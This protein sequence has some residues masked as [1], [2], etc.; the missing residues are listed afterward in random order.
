MSGPKFKKKYNDTTVEKT[1][2]FFRKRMSDKKESLIC[3]SVEK[4]LKECNEE[5]R[6]GIILYLNRFSKWY[7]KYYEKLPGD[8]FKRVYLKTICILWRNKNNERWAVMGLDETK[9][10]HDLMTHVSNL[11]AALFSSERYRLYN[12]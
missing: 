10:G 11:F 6:N 8:D 3:N 7:A 1:I 12:L 5:T 2:S 4:I 9:D